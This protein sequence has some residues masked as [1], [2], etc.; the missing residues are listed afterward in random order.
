M[1]FHSDDLLAVFR[2]LPDIIGW[3]GLIGFSSFALWLD[4]DL[5]LRTLDRCVKDF[6][7]GFNSWPVLFSNPVFGWG[8]FVSFSDLVRFEDSLRHSSCSGAKSCSLFRLDSL[9]ASLLCLFVRDLGIF[10]TFLINL[11]VVRWTIFFL[12]FSLTRLERYIV[13]R[14][15]VPDLISLQNAQQET[16]NNKIPNNKARQK[17]SK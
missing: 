1:N 17:N 10:N 8:E 5:C 13:P 4:S 7:I 11:L 12:G 15:P 9:E 6:R 3:P 14:I 16:L 2:A